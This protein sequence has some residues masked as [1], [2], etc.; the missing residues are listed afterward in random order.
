MTAKKDRRAA[1]ATAKCWLMSS[2]NRLELI[3][4][5]GHPCTFERKMLIIL[6]F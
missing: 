4:M 6:K 3:Q 1:L 5:C 2:Q